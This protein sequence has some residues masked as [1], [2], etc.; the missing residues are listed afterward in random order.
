MKKPLCVWCVLLTL[1]LFILFMIPVN[2]YWLASTLLLLVKNPN[3]KFI[4]FFTLFLLLRVMMF[5]LIIWSF[6][7]VLK[8]KKHA[9]KSAVISLMSILA[10][11]TYSR[12][13][14]SAPQLLSYDN[15]AQELGAV[16][17]AVIEVA[18]YL[19]IVL[20][21]V[22]SKGSKAYFSAGQKPD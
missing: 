12:L 21:F 14:T 22:F 1:S 15:E 2:L 7:A 4:F 19:A 18:W 8:R 3:F 10:F 5:T 13:F 11:F 17:G 16:L 9:R 20:R 6:I